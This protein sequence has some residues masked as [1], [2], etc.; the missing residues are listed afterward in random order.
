MSGQ[1]A[2][3]FVRVR[4][5]TTGFAQELNRQ[6]KPGLTQFENQL[7]S[8][9]RELGRF[10]RGALAGSGAV[11]HLG[12][13]KAFASG[14]FLGAAGFVAVVRSSISIAEKFEKA[15]R[16]LDAQLVASGQSAAAAAPLIAK[17]NLQ[18]ANLGITADESELALGRLI[19]ATGDTARA[20]RLMGLTA[21]LA[22]ARHISLGQAALVVGKIVQGNVVALNRYGLIIKA[23]T[24]VTDALRI[25]QQ[26]LAGQAQANVTPLERLHAAVADT[27]AA[28]G[29]ALLPTV[30]KLANSL[31]RWLSSSRNQERIQRDVEAAVRTSSAV[32]GGFVTALEDVKAVA[33]PLVGVIG[34]LGKAIGLMVTALAVRRV[35]SFASALGLVGPAAA[36]ATTGVAT[37]GAAA[38]TTASSLAV[39]TGSIGTAGALGKAGLAAETAVAASRVSLLRGAL[40]RLGT[41]GAIVIT[42]DE[43]VNRIVNGPQTKPPRGTRG[44][45]FGPDPAD[46]T[47]G[48]LPPL[49]NILGQLP[50]GGAFGA[51]NALTPNAK[52]QTS[53]YNFG[54]V[55][56][57]LAA[58]LTPS[59]QLKIALAANPNSIPLLN[60]QAAADRAALAFLRQRLADGKITQK[61]YVAAAVSYN[62]DLTSTVDH[63][64]QI[65]QTAADAAAKKAEN[66]AKKAKEARKKYRERIARIFTKTGEFQGGG[67]TYQQALGQTI[68]GGGNQPVQVG[69]YT[70]QELRAQAA[71]AQSRQD[72][73]GLQLL[74]NQLASAQLISNPT[75]QLSQERKVDELMVKYY[76][77][78]YNRLRKQKA[79]AL[80][81]AQAYGDVLTAQLAL[82]SLTKSKATGGFTLAQF[83]AEAE[84]E[85][86][87]YGS[88][89]AAPGSPLSPQEARGSVAGIAKQHQTVVIQNFNYPKSASQALNDAHA[90]ARN[91][92][93]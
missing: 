42:V 25:A 55:T 59:Q 92:K 5:L 77:A 3:A 11:S 37:L 20:T 83:Y 58:P 22:A 39:L 75:A 24:S 29:T 49:V 26:R 9:N 87:M 7:R 62:T 12:R 15:A 33:D 48:A 68:F 65:N 46:I 64:N 35:A 53:L 19:R 50:T 54:G 40:V 86:Q 73:I 56:N 36:S 8:S 44:L 72:A 6:I 85:A 45:P 60:Q 18:M 93:T 32:V 81:I 90:G 89:I 27:Q 79:G 57:P 16:G 43:I 74:Q 51:V 14:S 13:S 10:S 47:G 17:T 76:E 69:G 84:K 67:L 38:T 31:N 61:A 70:P 23:G 21:D 63:I 4:P 52:Q 82:K 2:E 30:D 28:I 41:L 34:G 71:K 66:A 1:I 91:L 78:I 88:N 80:K